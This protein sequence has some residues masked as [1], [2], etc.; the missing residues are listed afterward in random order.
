MT[1]RIYALRALQARIRN[2]T[3][4]DREL[5]C[6]IACAFLG[7][8]AYHMPDGYNGYRWVRRCPVDNAVFAPAT[9]TASLDACVALMAAVLPGYEWIRTDSREFGVWKTAERERGL[10]FYPLAT[11]CLT[12]LDAIFSAAI[13]EEEA[14]ERIT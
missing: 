3:G 4:A 9:Y 6:L 12:F 1:D 10:I 7:G 8:E 14:K 5:D 2:S 13:A 11:D